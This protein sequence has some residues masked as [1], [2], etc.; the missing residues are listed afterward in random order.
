MNVMTYYKFQPKDILK[1]IRNSYRIKRECKKKI[2]NIF[3]IKLCFMPHVYPSSE[4]RTTRFLLRNLR[5]I[6]KKK[7]IC[8]M[9]CGPGIVGLFALRK[10]ASFVVQADINKYAYENAKFNNLLNNYKQD[11][12]ETYLSDCFDNIPKQNFDVI[13]FNMPFHNDKI[14]IK[15]PIQYAFYDPE[16]KS[17]K[18]FLFQAKN[19]L[20]SDSQMF[21]AFSN[22]GDCAELESLFLKYKYEYE[23]WK[24]INT[25]KDYDNRIYRLRKSNI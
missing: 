17:I 7:N 25:N 6:F 3:G 10:G 20:H 19:Y 1:K 12:I 14:E 16:F 15:D 9:G 23:L 13:I 24:I 11:Q 4:F 8:D 5:K 21:I 18:K 2:D 22:K